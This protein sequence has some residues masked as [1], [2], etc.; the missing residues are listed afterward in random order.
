MEVTCLSIRAR[1]R[2]KTTYKCIIAFF[3]LRD[4]IESVRPKWGCKKEVG[5]VLFYNIVLIAHKEEK[6]CHTYIMDWQCQAYL[7]HA[8]NTCYG[9]YHIES[10]T[11]KMLDNGSNSWNRRLNVYWKDKN[12]SK[13]IGSARKQEGEV[14]QILGRVR[15]CS[16]DRSWKCKGSELERELWVCTSWLH[17][18]GCI[19]YVLKFW[20][21]E[22][23]L[24][25]QAEGGNGIGF[26]NISNSDKMVLSIIGSVLWGC[27]FLQ[28]A[29][30]G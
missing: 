8:W 14:S 24:G 30:K 26:K 20:K 4:V 18:R 1:A 6:Q 12:E 16:G 25:V 10:E 28:S 3:K 7:Q 15:C 13:H 23:V 29:F 27:S 17:F 22:I 5:V 9:K 19:G 2:K 21:T 11:W